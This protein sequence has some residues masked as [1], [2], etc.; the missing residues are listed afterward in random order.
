MKTIK[1]LHIDGDYRVVYLL[2][3]NGVLIKTPLALEKAISLL[4]SEDFDLILFEPQNMAILTPLEGQA[5]MEPILEKFMNNNNE[6]ESAL[7]PN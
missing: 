5:L 3:R 4:H 6:E 7:R 2:I 1:V